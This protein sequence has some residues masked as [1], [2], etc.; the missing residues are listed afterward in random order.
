MSS[1]PLISCVMVTADRHR[2]CG[3]AIKSYI[4]QSY[5][6]K[7]LIVL[8]NGETPM[9]D[10]LVDVP[11]SEIRYTRVTKTPDMTLGDLRNESLSLVGGD[12]V[13]P[14]WD[15]DDWSPPNR[16]EYQYQSLVS[17]EVEAC[18]LLATLMHV[19][20]PRY[21]D[22]PFLGLLAGGVPPTIMHRRDDSVRFP[23]LPRKGD[24]VYKSAWMKRPYLI[25]PMS[26]SHLYMRYF[27]GDN[28]WEI[29]HFLRRMRNTPKDFIAYGWWKYVRRNEFGHSRFRLSDDARKTFQLYLDDSRSAGVFT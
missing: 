15:D 13:V 26:D 22:N 25:L 10:L 9:D 23:S 1:L 4:D 21:F 11:D 5:P 24:T 16:L 19:D 27:H 7:E 28:V 20:H 2:F 12:I 3:R 6:N 18:T 8:D 17:H 14:Q 29:D